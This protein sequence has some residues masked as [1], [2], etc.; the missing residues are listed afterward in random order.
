VGIFEPVPM[1]WF[2]GVREINAL[3]I[4]RREGVDL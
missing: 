4:F 2:D 3:L 1:D